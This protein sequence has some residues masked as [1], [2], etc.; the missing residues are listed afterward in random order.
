MR[1][2]V[3][4]IAADIPKAEK[5]VRSLARRGCMV[6]G[7]TAMLACPNDREKH[8]SPQVSLHQPALGPPPDWPRKRD[9]ASSVRVTAQARISGS[10]AS[11][12][13]EPGVEQRPATVTANP[14]TTQ[15][16]WCGIT[17]DLCE[18]GL[19]QEDAQRIAAEVHLNGVILLVEERRDCC[20]DDIIDA[21]LTSGLT[22]V[23][24]VLMADTPVCRSDASAVSAASAV[25]GACDRPGCSQS[26][27]AWPWNFSHF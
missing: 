8:Q 16:S 20:A 26:F 15:S 22:R 19:A 24:M 13:V 23:Y 3:L 5:V 4:G 11:A 2:V 17:R 18:L 1:M 7:L 25:G 9:P 12:L 14:P 27:P 6:D 10:G 21:L